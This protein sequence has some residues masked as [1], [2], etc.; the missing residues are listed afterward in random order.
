MHKTTET[1][2]QLETQT[3]ESEEDSNSDESMMEEETTDGD[4]IGRFPTFH[5]GLHRLSSLGTLLKASVPRR[6]KRLV[7]LLVAILEVDGPTV[8]TT[9]SGVE[10]GLLKLIIGDDTGAVAKMVVWRET[11]LKWG[12]GED[13]SAEGAVRKGDVVYLESKCNQP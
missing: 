3:D 10:M 7:C 9:K 12:G 13:R 5:F 8:I 2:T 4:S 11:A 1:G 6:E